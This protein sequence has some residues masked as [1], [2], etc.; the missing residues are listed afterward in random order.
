MGI[1]YVVFVYLPVS[2]LYSDTVTSVTCYYYSVNPQEHFKAYSGS[3][4]E[5]HS[6][7]CSLLC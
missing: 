4:K 3:L 5:Y 1:F 2:V 6:P 7:L